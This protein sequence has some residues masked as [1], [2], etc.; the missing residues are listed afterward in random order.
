M[1]LRTASRTLKGTETA[2]GYGAPPPPSSTLIFLFVLKDS[3]SLPGH[4]RLGYSWRDRRSFSFNHN[5]VPQTR[6]VFPSP[7][8][9]YT[10]G[11]S[12][13]VASDL[14]L[15]RQTNLGH[16][17][18]RDRHRQGSL[19]PSVNAQRGCLSIGLTE[20]HSGAAVVSAR[21]PFS[22]ARG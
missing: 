6:P 12:L 19:G 4:Y 16:F 10:G 17:Y 9:S 20:S 14:I 5:L 3:S 11:I 1:T 22:L 21:V 8:S 15:S 2:W 7:E 13:S 18:P